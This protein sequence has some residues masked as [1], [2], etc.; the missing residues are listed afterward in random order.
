MTQ[1]GVS[2]TP[3]QT[4]KQHIS[5]TLT[6]LHHEMPHRHGDSNAGGGHENHITACPFRTQG[7]QSITTTYK[8]TLNILTHYNSIGV[9][10]SRPRLPV[11]RAWITAGSVMRD[12]ISSSTASST[13]ILTAAESPLFLDLLLLSVLRHIQRNSPSKCANFISCTFLKSLA[14]DSSKHSTCSWYDCAEHAS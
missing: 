9:F 1:Q 12:W 11:M 4:R 5:F 2:L 8:G 7:V 13:D 14:V 6:L 10:L 3:Q